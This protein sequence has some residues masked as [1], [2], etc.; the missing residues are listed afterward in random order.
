MRTLT[1]LLLLAAA[2]LH[3]ATFSW[4]ATKTRTVTHGPCD[5]VSAGPGEVISNGGITAAFGANFSYNQINPDPLTYECD[6]IMGGLF[7]PEDHGDWTVSFDWGCTGTVPKNGITF[8]PPVQYFAVDIMG[9]DRIH[10][11]MCEGWL[12]S[13]DGG[14]TWNTRCHGHPLTVGSLEY[15]EGTAW[16]E[17]WTPTSQVVAT[18][19]VATIDGWNGCDT[20]PPPGP[21]WDWSHNERPYCNWQR[22]EVFSAVPFNRVWFK[23]FNATLPLTPLYLDN[24]VAST[25]ECPYPPCSFER[26][27]LP[28]SEDLPLGVHESP[29]TMKAPAL[30]FRKADGATPTQRTSWG[31]LKVIYR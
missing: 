7:R 20:D 19:P 23:G 5:F 31:A 15:D 9:T 28:R 3:A 6:Y 22:V 16:L 12:C 21:P 8:N 26:A 4:D 13:A 30:M 29:P 14:L 24:F 25:T 10:G 27:G 11:F 17:A 18:S 1:L 2:P